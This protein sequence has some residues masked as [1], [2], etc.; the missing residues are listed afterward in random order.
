MS[1]SKDKAPGFDFSQTGLD[2]QPIVSGVNK[3]EGEGLVR[4]GVEPHL[5]DISTWIPT[6]S[7]GL[8]NA[9]SDGKGLGG[10]RIYLIYGP[11]GAGKSTTLQEIMVQAQRAGGLS[12]LLDEEAKWLRSRAH[13]IG[14]DDTKHLSFEV[15]DIEGGFRCIHETVM[16]IH[17]QGD[18]VRKKKDELEKKVNKMRKASK[19]RDEFEADLKR[20]ES[21][22]AV[23]EDIPIVIGWDTITASSMGQGVD[24]RAKKKKRSQAEQ[25]A[26]DEKLFKPRML[27]ALLKKYTKFFSR[28]NVTV[29]FV[30]QTI[31]KFKKGGYEAYMA[32]ACGGMGIQFHATASMEL[33]YNGYLRWVTDGPIMGV[34]TGINID[35]NQLAA[36]YR[37]TNVYILPDGFN[38]YVEAFETIKDLGLTFE[39]GGQRYLVAQSSGGW[40]YVQHPDMDPLAFRYSELPQKL[41]ENKPYYHWLLDAVELAHN[42]KWW[43]LYGG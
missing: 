7:P 17:E 1:K 21:R 41:K 19:Q 42:N 12:I 36:P 4:M 20:L 43:E 30:A 15:H 31:T 23:F 16:A 26:E 9:L 24:E 11:P 3:L 29:V 2:L 10:G 28:F 13:A 6:G 14:H 40:Y 33:F 35:K 32:P 38:V 34:R 8:D 18:A 25:A 22:A 5:A 39:K 27:R 37:K